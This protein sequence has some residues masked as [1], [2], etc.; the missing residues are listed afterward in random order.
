MLRRC[1]NVW[2]LFCAANDFGSLSNVGVRTRGK[3]NPGPEGAEASE[4]EGEAFAGFQ[5]EIHYV[6][7]FISSGRCHEVEHASLRAYAC[8]SRSEKRSITSTAA[9]SSLQGFRAISHHVKAVDDDFRVRKERLRCVPE[10]AV[11][12]HDDVF[13]LVAIG[14]RAQVILNRLHGSRRQNI[15]NAANQRVGDDVLEALAARVALEF[16]EGNGFE[17]GAIFSSRCTPLIETPVSFATSL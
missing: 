8:K 7:G 1:F 6:F 3:Q 17:P 15:E 10:A 12:V 5:P 16:V 11:H 14:K 4:T 2:A 9:R 13:H